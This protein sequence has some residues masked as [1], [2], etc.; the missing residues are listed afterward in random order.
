M[1]KS[2]AITRLNRKRSF[3]ISKAINTPGEVLAGMLAKLEEQIVQPVAQ[4]DAGN[5]AKQALTRVRDWVGSYLEVNDVDKRL[6]EWIQN[7][8]HPNPSVAGPAERARRPLAQAQVQV[9][10]VEGKPGWYE[11]VAHL[12]P[13]FQLEGIDI[14][15]RLVGKLPA[16][17]E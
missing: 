13:H 9:K 11:A 12:R 10:P 6:N 2:L 5:W 17:K 8:V 15:M 16:K 14:S 7:Y 3:S 1:I 4:E